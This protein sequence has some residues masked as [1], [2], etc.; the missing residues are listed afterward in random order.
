MNIVSLPGPQHLPYLFPPSFYTEIIELVA[1]AT[2][3]AVGVAA[4][5][6]ACWATHGY[7]LTS[8]IYHSP[9]A[10]CTP[11]TDLLEHTRHVQ[12]PELALPSAW[13]SL[14]QIGTWLIQSLHQEFAHRETSWLLY[15]KL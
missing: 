6:S 7:L 10:L 4:A 1:A 13:K 8:L 2:V 12:G 5:G 9:L 11:S 15:L 14:P 3:I